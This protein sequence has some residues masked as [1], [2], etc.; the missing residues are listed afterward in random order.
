MQDTNIKLCVCVG[1]RGKST[2]GHE[3]DQRVQIQCV[4]THSEPLYSSLE[5]IQD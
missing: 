3:P 5:E 2:A 4:L 1:Q